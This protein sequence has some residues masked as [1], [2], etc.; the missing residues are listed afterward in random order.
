MIEIVVCKNC[1]YL[2]IKF[3]FFVRSSGNNKVICQNEKLGLKM[4]IEY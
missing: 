3:I 2:D 1:E 4:K